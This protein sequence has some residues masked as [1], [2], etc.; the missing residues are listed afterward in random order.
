MIS[1]MNDDIEKSAERF[2]IPPQNLEDLLR[3]ASRAKDVAYCKLSE[4][5][6]KE[7]PFICILIAAT[8]SS[9]NTNPAASQSSYAIMEAYLC[10]F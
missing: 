1:Q 5:L 10:M 8:I 3:R 6:C 2:N 9:V 7:V 4:I